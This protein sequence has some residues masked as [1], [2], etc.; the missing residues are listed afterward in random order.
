MNHSDELHN[1]SINFSSNIEYIVLFLKVDYEKNWN[2]IISE[3][4]ISVERSGAFE[5]CCFE[6]LT[7]L[8]SGLSIWS[9][10]ESLF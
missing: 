8:R 6:K 7:N 4:K 10:G 3:E 2:K 9:G 1:I 5:G